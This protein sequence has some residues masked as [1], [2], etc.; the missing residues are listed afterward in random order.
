MA[1]CRPGAKPLSEP[2]I[3]SLPM[4]ICVT[5]P[6]WVNVKFSSW[7]LMT[8]LQHI[9]GCLQTQRWL[10]IGICMYRDQHLPDSKVRGATMGPTWVLSAPDGPHVGPMNL[11]IRAVFQLCLSKVPAII[12]RRCYICKVFSHWLRPCSAIDRKWALVLYIK[13]PD[14][15]ILTCRST[16]HE[17]GCS[18]NIFGI[19]SP[20]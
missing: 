12:E 6:Q 3:V 17:E 2:M 18:Q 10:N 5:R 9:S 13:L 19:Y 7:E 15:M 11:A 16:F 14:I 4:Y 20:I 8:W 1:W